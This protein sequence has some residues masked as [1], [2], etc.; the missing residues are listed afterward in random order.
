MP[1]TVR[2][3]YATGASLGYSLERLADGLLFDF[4]GATFVSSP[5]TLVASLPE[6]T[7]NF[8]GLY[9]ATLT[10]TP[11]AQ[12]PDGDYSLNVHDTNDANLVVGV[13]TKVLA[14]GV[15]V[16]AGSGGSGGSGGGGPALTTDQAAVLAALGSMISG[17]EFT[18]G[19]LTHAPAAAAATTTG[20][21]SAA[22]GA[23]SPGGSAS[24]APAGGAGVDQDYGTPGAL[25]Y[26]GPGVGAVQ[27]YL[28]ADYALYR[29]A[30]AVKGTAVI[31]PDG[32]WRAPIPL[33]PGAYLLIFSRPGAPG[34]QAALQVS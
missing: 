24:A 14:G 9:G 32:S 17:G 11:T 12:F 10:S 7:P 34:R 26:P 1:I 18:A 3:P 30:A 5:A 16:A 21:G 23:S 19:A 28:Q 31:N 6:L 20:S 33:A 25:K 13:G 2:F 15:E 29:G 8:P 4:T 27:A 22:A